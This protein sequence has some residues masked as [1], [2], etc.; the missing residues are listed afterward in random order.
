[1]TASQSLEDRDMDS[2]P[3]LLNSSSTK[4]T[5]LQSESPSSS[6]LSQRETKSTPSA[7]LL[8]HNLT[9]PPVL[10]TMVTSSSN[11]SS[12]HN[13]TILFPDSPTVA[14]EIL[15]N[16]TRRDVSVS[17]PAPSREDEDLKRPVSLTFPGRTAEETVH[18]VTSL[19]TRRRLNSS[20]MGTFLKNS[21]LTLQVGTNA[22]LA[23]FVSSEQLQ[24]ILQ[25][26]SS[27]SET[28]LR[29]PSQA[30]KTPS[31][32]KVTP[33]SPCSPHPPIPFEYPSIS[34]YAM[35]KRR[36]PFNSSRRGLPHS[37]F[38]TG[39]EVPNCRKTQ[40]PNPGSSTVNETPLHFHNTNHEV[41]E[42]NKEAEEAEDKQEATELCQRCISRSQKC[43]VWHSAGPEVEKGGDGKQR[44]HHIRDSSGYWDSDSSSS[45]DYC[46][47]HRPYCDPCL[48]RGSLLCSG[49]S[50]DS[51]DSEYDDFTDLYPSSSRPVVFKD[52]IKPTLV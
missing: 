39:S 18:F 3:T 2:S 28:S 16:E 51:S 44:S 42:E 9:L 43:S 52:D 21:D 24:E 40:Y 36:P 33:L 26:L 15:M 27:L 12:T 7:H 47:Y 41:E 22:K 19:Q 50:S 38:Y 46:Y 23:G 5:E 30:L 31:Q 17:D 4:T 6:Y 37:Y 25:E 32:L 34:P 29:S 35:R 13:P 1:M 20:Q 14:E 48:H 49:S 10:S 45:T 11:S 8:S